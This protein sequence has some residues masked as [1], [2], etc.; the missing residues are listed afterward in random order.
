MKITLET[1]G[2]KI[3][4]ETPGDDVDITE[5]ISILKGLLV[6]AEFHPYTVDEVFSSDVGDGSWN[7]RHEPVDDYLLTNQ[8]I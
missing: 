2:K 6:Q 7:L 4:V 5:M 1:H 8:T 3:H